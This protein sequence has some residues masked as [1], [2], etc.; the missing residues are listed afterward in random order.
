[1][2]WMEGERMAQERKK[3]TRAATSKRRKGLLSPQK[4]ADRLAA[5][6]QS[7]LAKLTPSQRQ[8][9]LRAF[10][11]VVDGIGAPR[12]RSPGTSQIQ[13]TLLAARGR[14]GR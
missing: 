10:R 1:M 7:Y 9:K 11:R 14:E 4:V 5:M 8:A 13:P 3:P 12:A 6:T 2:G